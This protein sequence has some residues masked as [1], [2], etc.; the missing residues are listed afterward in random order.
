MDRVSTT[1]RHF[2]KDINT[3]RIT[4]YSELVAQFIDKDKIRELKEKCTG[5]PWSF[6]KEKRAKLGVLFQAS[7]YR[8]ILDE[9]HA[10]KCHTSLS[11]F[12]TK[13]HIP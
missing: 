6:R 5:D 12:F 7:W 2:S 10:I 11:A 8:V 1:N 13:S 4:T 3:N 9:A